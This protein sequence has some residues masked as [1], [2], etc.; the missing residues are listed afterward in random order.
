M[1]YIIIPK[2]Q[3]SLYRKRKITWFH[4]IDAVEL[5]DGT[6]TLPE[7]VINGM[8]RFPAK[9]REVILQDLSKST[10]DVELA[11]LPTTDKPVF[12]DPELLDDAKI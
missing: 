5:K 1:N 3:A 10:Y 12:P 11:K 7:R 9:Q 4:G 8:K 6:F 2:A